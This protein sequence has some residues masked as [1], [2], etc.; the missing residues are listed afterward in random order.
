MNEDAAR[1]EVIDSL[2]GD[3]PPDFGSATPPPVNGA[4]TSEPPPQRRRPPR[5]APKADG[6]Q[7]KS[8][9]PKTSPRQPSIEKQ[10]EEFFG[11]IAVAIGATGDMYC[12]QVVATQ[13]KPLADAWGEL[14]RKNDRVRAIIERMMEGS[15]WGGVVFA[16]M[17]TVIPIAAHH[18]LYPKG[19][20]MPFDFGI[21]PPPPPSEEVSGEQSRTG[22]PSAGPPPA[23]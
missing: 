12:A 9:R 2:T 18:G 5:R 10:L 22:H 14:A 20:P 3:S 13:A 8:P 21:G 6:E 15:T 17:V 7:P 16:T 4:G 1:Q 11:F 23:P 19:M